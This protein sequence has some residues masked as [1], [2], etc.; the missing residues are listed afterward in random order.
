MQVLQSFYTWNIYVFLKKDFEAV[1]CYDENFY[2]AQD[3]KLVKD[4]F[5]NNYKILY[6]KD[7]FTYLEGRPKVLVLKHRSHQKKFF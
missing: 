3:F 6:I 1:G 4:F 5:K 2:Y 7:Q